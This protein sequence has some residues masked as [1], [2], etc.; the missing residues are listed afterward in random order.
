MIDDDCVNLNFFFSISGRFAL[1]IIMGSRRSI[2]DKK[3]GKRLLCLG[4]A[5]YVV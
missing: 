1:R 3:R 5:N 2:N 4:H